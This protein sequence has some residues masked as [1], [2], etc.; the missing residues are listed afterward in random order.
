MI[1]KILDN[2]FTHKYIVMMQL[3]AKKYDINIKINIQKNNIVTVFIKKLN[4]KEKYYRL[5]RIFH[6][7]DSVYLL[8]DME[9]GINYFK[10][11]IE[12]YLKKE[13]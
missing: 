3:I 9:N 4:A 6:K 5:I 10:N 1:N 7:S 2:Y 12:E 11:L 8:F 13:M